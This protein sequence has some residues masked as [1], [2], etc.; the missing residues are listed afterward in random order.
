MDDT[1]SNPTRSLILDFISSHPGTSAREIQRSLAL[2]WGETSYHLN[3]LLR[4]A[5]IRRDRR[6][7]RDYFFPAGFP[8]EDQRILTAFQGEAERAV[9]VSLSQEPEQSFLELMVGLKMSRSH[10][11]LHLRLLLATNLIGLDPTRSPHRYY[12]LHP[13]RVLFLYRT[14]RRSWGDRWIDRFATAFS[15]II[16]P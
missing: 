8:I 7:W 15:G 14:Y 1:R 2:A 16:R 13:E 6:S 5:A 9:L 3:Q 11:S 10:L 4:S 12:A